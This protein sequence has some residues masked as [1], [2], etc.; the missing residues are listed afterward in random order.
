RF[1]SPW[2]FPGGGNPSFGGKIYKSV[3]INFV[4][5]RS[6]VEYITEFKLKFKAGGAAGFSS[7]LN[8]V[9]ASTAVSILV[10]VPADQHIIT[11]IDEEEAEVSNESCSCA[12]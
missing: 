8:E 6:Y 2:A 5:D 1:L 4:E 9:I 3:L 12:S 11:P 7:D 10:S